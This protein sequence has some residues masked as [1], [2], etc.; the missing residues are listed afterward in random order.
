MIKL[1]E[2]IDQT[3]DSPKLY[4]RDK[5]W[6]SWN[7]KTD[8]GGDVL[9]VLKKNKKKHYVYQR[10]GASSISITDLDGKKYMSIK[11]SEVYQVVELPQTGYVS[12]HPELK[13]WGFR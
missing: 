10:G 13:K 7:K 6:K 8:K 4:K 11:P 2:L 1:M 3:V 12:K 9:V 5:S